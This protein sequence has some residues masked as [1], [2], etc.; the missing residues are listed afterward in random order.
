MA[1]QE[2]HQDRGLRACVLTAQ[3]W[4]AGLQELGQAAAPSASS[5]P[6]SCCLTHRLGRAALTFP[7]TLRIKK[8]LE[9]VS[10]GTS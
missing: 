8:G 9:L 5:G 7:Q 3:F 6:A 1:A 2:E 10:Y 4:Q